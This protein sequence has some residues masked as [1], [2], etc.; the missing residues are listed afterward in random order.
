MRRLGPF[1]AAIAGLWIAGALQQ[2]C[3]RALS[4]G[5][6]SPD[7]LI[8]L[9]A[10]AS[11]L[12]SRTGAAF[13]GFGAGVVQGALPGANLMHYVISRTVAAFFTAWAQDL[14]LAPHSGTIFLTGVFTTVLAQILFMFLAAP[15]GI[16]AYLGATIASAIY[17]G[18]LCVPLHGGLRRA[19]KTEYR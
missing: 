7:F 13:L 9:I 19:L 8:I 10:A 14:K 12:M 18:L 17:N 3:S 2:S 16:I 5:P 1:F 4:I 6:A 11:P 15:P